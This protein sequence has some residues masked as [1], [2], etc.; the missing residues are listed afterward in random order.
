MTRNDPSNAGCQ[1]DPEKIALL[2]VDALVPDDA[3]DVR[4]AVEAAAIPHSFNTEIPAATAP[5]CSQAP[6]AIAL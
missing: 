6:V 3:N 5:A 1:G 4:E 2:T